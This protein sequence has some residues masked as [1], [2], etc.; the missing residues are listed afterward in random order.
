MYGKSSMSEFGEIPPVVS[1]ATEP[2]EVPT[3]PGGGGNGV[4]SLDDQNVSYGLEDVDGGSDGICDFEG[5][6]G[7]VYSDLAIMPRG[8]AG[9]QLTLSYCGQVYVF[10][11]VTTDKVEVSTLVFFDYC[12]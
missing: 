5:I 7:V 12:F 10:D 6:D 9:D 11:N 8:D 3:H 4:D 1:G 2:E